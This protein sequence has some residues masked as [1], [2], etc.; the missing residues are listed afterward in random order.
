LPSAPGLRISVA[1]C[2]YNGA[3]HLEAQLR[4]IATQERLPDELVV[5]D[6]GS[7]DGSREI[8][9]EF[10]STAVF[11]TRL[12]KNEQNL[13]STRNFERAISLC[14]GDVVAFADQDDVWYPQK[15]SWIENT[16]LDAD[17]IA[18]F[19][20]ADVIDENSQPMGWRLW[21]TFGFDAAKQREFGKGNAL[22]VLAKGYV[23][24]GA[25]TAFRRECFDRMAPI[26]E[27]Q[28]HDAWISFLLA[29]L[30]KIRAIPRPLMQYRV[31]AGQQIGIGK[32][33]LS[34]RR[35]T[36][37]AK[38]KDRQ[39]RV[40]EIRRYEALDEFLNRRREDFP[41]APRAL[42]VL[43][44]KLCHLRRRAQMPASRIAR[45]PAVLRETIN[46]AYWAYAN[47]WKSAA[48]DLLLK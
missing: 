26:P 44:G 35:Q 29:A 39:F 43:R 33:R 10:A 8:I 19:S 28:I 14:R 46:G 7:S 13:G 4:S 15:L 40:V 9:E 36:E 37:I 25:A 16:M 32:N 48:K 6:D 18:T 47:G 2:S 21:S 5:C 12:T 34:L 11:P 23:M 30:G 20:D 3:R 31:H 41:Y 17:V 45:F 27:N 24:T 22:E 38:K 42:Q 1:M